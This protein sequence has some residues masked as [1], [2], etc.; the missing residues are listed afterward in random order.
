MLALFGEFNCAVDNKGRLRLPSGLK[1]KIGEGEQQ[2]VLKRGFEGC[3]E[4]W[5]AA[6]WEAHLAQILGK[7]DDFNPD[8]REFR[9]GYLAGL[10]EVKSDSAERI[11]IPK[12]LTEAASIENEVTLQGAG[13]K[14]EIFPTKK[15][16]EKYVQKTD[17]FHQMAN[18][19]MSRAAKR[20]EEPT[21][22]INV[23]K[24]DEK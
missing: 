16:E 1:A 23:Q 6:N 22:S 12:F 14:I 24:N 9:R 8:D 19:V 10:A 15:Y 7:L 5:P 4:L 2:F 3:L 17:D 13:E 20:A 21:F 11:L 18:R